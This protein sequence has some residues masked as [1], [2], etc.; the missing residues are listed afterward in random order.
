[1]NKNLILLFGCF[2]NFA[3]YATQENRKKEVAEIE[4]SPN[5]FYIKDKDR[6]NEAPDGKIGEFKIQVLQNAVRNADASISFKIRMYGI[7]NYAGDIYL[8][9]VTGEQ[10]LE[11]DKGDQDDGRT[12][13]V[14]VPKEKLKNEIFTGTLRFKADNLRK[15]SD[16]IEFEEVRFKVKPEV[17]LRTDTKAVNF[18][19]LVP[20]NRKIAT[21]KKPVK[22]Q[23]SILA[24]S[25]CKVS[26][27]NE[28]RLKHTELEGKYIPYDIECNRSENKVE[29]IRVGDKLEKNIELETTKE[30]LNVTFVI[31]ELDWLPLAGVYKD[32][33]TFSLV[34]KK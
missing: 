24:D 22:F 27:E 30:E 26:S 17:F 20:D 3:I 15:S 4:I 11:Q 34:P 14:V 31:H 19:R 29:N 23:Y 18:G 32:T 10:K 13:I 16:R 12:A 33:V 8:Q 1:M 9:N 2:L 28:F 25:C 7:R 6:R 21:V 5:S